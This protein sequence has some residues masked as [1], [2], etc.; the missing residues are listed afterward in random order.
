MLRAFFFEGKDHITL[1]AR[2]EAFEMLRQWLLS[3]A[4]EI[5]L[6]QRTTGQLCVVA[7]EIF[8]NIARYGYPHGE[9]TADVAIA[10]DTEEHQ[11]QLT[12]TDNGIP[13]NPLDLAKDPDTTLPATQRTP[14]GLGLF[15]VKNIMD[16]VSY[17]REDD[18]NILKMKKNFGQ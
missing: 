5:N 11:L 18:K 2:V 15:L 3:I 7:D 1:P 16:E 6:S 14:G 8:T 9:G 10:V 13:C 12:F 4:A 17:T